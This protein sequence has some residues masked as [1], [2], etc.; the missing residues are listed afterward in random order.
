[1]TRKRIVNHAGAAW[2][3]AVAGAWIVAAACRTMQ[4]GASSGAPQAPPP[5][6]AL[7][8]TVL[9]PSI[10]V[11][12]L[13]DVER[14]SIG[15]DG[16]V[17]VRGRAPGEKAV[18]LRSLPR[19]TFRAGGAP[20]RIRL[21]ETGDELELATLAPSDASEILQAD[22]SPYRGI[23]EVRPAEAGR[24]TVVN[25]VH[26]EDYVRGV[27]P[28]ELSP[29]AFPRIEALKAQAVAAR[30][31]AL[32]HLG[33][34][35]AKGYDVCATAA[36][37]VYRGQSS[38]H[39][40]T[41]RAVAETRGIL[42]T[43]HGRPI[44]AY[45]TST[46]GGH[47]EDGAPIFD[48]DAPYLRG[49][50]CL[51]EASSRHTVR[52]AASPRR[53]LPG[54]PG[55]SR[56]VALLEALGVIDAGEADPARL[57]GIPTDAEVRAWTAG[58][59]AALHRPACD[60]P[61]SGAF[62]R[63]ATFAR[64]LV[65]SVCWTERAERLLAR[66]DTA[67]LLQVEDA[68]KLDGDER[69]AV[70]LLVHEGLL[71]PGPDN[72]IRPDA[73]LTRAEALAL[74]AGVAD[75]GGAPALA[76]GELAGLAGG[77]IS[78]LHGETADS[79]PLDVGVRLFRDLDGAHAGTSELT[80]SV[81]DRVV[82]VERAGRVVYLEAEQTRRG[83]SA[84]RSSRYYN[85]EV[86]L[87]PAD[88]ARAIGRYGSVGQ[89]RDIVP[90]RLGVSGRVVELGVLGSTGELDLKGLQVRW[91]LGLRESLFVVNRETSPRGEVERFVITGKGWG[92]GV[93]LCQVGAYG[94]ALAGSTFE[95]ILKHYYTGI[96]LT[97]DPREARVDL[98]ASSRGPLAWASPR[99]PSLPRVASAR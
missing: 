95:E 83:A 82:Y 34:Y 27:V 59:Q 76:E 75:K 9:A 86:R 18:R 36:C 39:P 35:A 80:L 21:L 25:T 28:N 52:T 79:H 31:Y 58:L 67:Y 96:S 40:L 19:A 20:G 53:D 87:T 14:V 63:R 1:V 45:Y 66:A 10:R 51:P 4:G 54:G 64:Y 12:V 6:A 23:L 99:P 88:V 68:A 47:T 3:A 46:C 33:D 89:V 48:D 60:S 5:D 97:H 24:I 70:A 44:N 43:W 93:G 81:G 15:A 7:S 50:A 72:T 37:Q 26:L 91:G 71:S 74:L 90:K 98:G 56:D 41:D 62:A 42:A 29:E 16:G 73:A 61:V 30:T 92:H 65:A 32:A 22:A 84:D 57:R 8:A 77:E 94:M 38:E 13:T 55:T 69:Q 17:E 85:W 49:V 11:G 2:L 78:V